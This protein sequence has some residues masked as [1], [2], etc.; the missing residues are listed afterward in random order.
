[1]PTTLFWEVFYILRKWNRG[2]RSAKI[3]MYA[4]I[5]SVLKWVSQRQENDK[6]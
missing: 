3:K 1:M 5:Q 2:E 4:H 6:D